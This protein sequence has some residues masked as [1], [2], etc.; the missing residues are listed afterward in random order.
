MAE[1]IDVR[2]A[3]A[4]RVIV[5]DFSATILR[6][7]KIGLIGVNGAGKTTLL[8]LILGEQ[9]PD[10]GT[11]RQGSRL[12]IAYFDQMRE[13]LNEE[14]SLADTISPGSDWVE[15]NGDR[16]HV[17][18]YLGDFL[19]ARVVSAIAYCWRDCSPNRLMCWCWMNPPMIW[20]SIPWSYSSS[21]W[22]IMPA[23][24]SWSVMIVCFS[25]MSSPRYLSQKVKE[26][27]ASI[28]VATAIGSVYAH[29]AQ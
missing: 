8:R 25:I 5:K 29:P 16:K 21:C 22:R 23:P 18:T 14:S 15:V 17:M 28:L 19:F 3:Y 13:Q 1:L 9:K 27:G 10:A 2:K 26:F 24:Y 6:G 7:D 11:L 12:Q 20:I 4:D